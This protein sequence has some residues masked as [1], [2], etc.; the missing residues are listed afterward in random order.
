MN[1]Q[2]LLLDI[3]TD[4]GLLQ[5]ASVVREACSMLFLYWST[6]DACDAAVMTGN[7]K[8]MEDARTAHN[9]AQDVVAHWWGTKFGDAK[10]PHEYS[11]QKTGGH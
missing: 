2:K 8:V 6:L 7:R 11:V 4:D 10:D 9:S 1:H 5:H 3:H